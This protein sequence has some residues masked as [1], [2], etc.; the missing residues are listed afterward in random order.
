MGETDEE[1]TGDATSD[2]RASDP[3]GGQPDSDERTICRFLSENPDR[4]PTPPD[5][6][7]VL[8]VSTLDALV[9]TLETAPVDAVVC[10]CTPRSTETVFTT[11]TLLR[12][13]H[14]DVPLL[15]WTATADERG[16]LGVRA[17]RHDVDEFVTQHVLDLDG[18]DIYDRVEVAARRNDRDH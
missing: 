4:W 17:S 16:E 9:S 12:E 11:V 10:D 14:P 15:L 2:A 1:T 3:A 13:H 5:G 7:T 8:D 6:T 18:E